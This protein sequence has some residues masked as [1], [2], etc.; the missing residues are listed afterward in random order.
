MKDLAIKSVNGLFGVAFLLVAIP[1]VAPA[2]VIC[3]IFGID[4]MSMDGMGLGFFMMVA[5][6][7]GIAIATGFFALGYIL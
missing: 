7:I 4:P 6:A 5:I 3:R 1:F 2:Y